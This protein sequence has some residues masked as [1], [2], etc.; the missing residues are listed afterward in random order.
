MV[1]EGMVVSE[2]VLL[3]SEAG[4]L[5]VEAGACLNNAP[6]WHNSRYASYEQSY[7]PRSK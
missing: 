5:V 1:R 3:V 2:A 7:R 6:K 4:V